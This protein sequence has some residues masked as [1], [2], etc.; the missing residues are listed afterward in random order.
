MRTG[1]ALIST[2]ANSGMTV[3]DSVFAHNDAVL[4]G[5]AIY[6]GEQHEDALVVRNSVIEFNTAYRAGG[7]CYHYM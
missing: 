1:G 6:F 3:E 2:L 5:G 4:Y 7:E